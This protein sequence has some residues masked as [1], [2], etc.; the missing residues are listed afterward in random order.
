MPDNKSVMDAINERRQKEKDFKEM[1]AEQKKEWGEVVNRLFSTRDGQYFAAGLIKFCKVFSV[2]PVGNG[3]NLIEMKG[4]RD[5]YLSLIR[6]YLD[7]TV[8]NE[9]E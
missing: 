7:K 9:I 2:D 3:V 6:P 8:K 5:T 1:T 4:R